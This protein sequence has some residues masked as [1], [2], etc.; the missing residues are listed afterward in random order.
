[1]SFQYRRCY[2]QST[3]EKYIISITFDISRYGKHTKMLSF[4]EHLSE[5]EAIIKVESYLSEPITKAYFN[6]VRDDLFDDDLT[7]ETLNEKG[8]KC[9]GD[10]LTD[11]KFLEG[12]RLLSRSFPEDVYIVTGS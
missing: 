3:D 8:Y 1:M 2:H 9:R 7:F 5:E 11:A 4:S 10:L 6:L 12:I